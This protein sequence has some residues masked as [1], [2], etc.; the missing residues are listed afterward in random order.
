MWT[1]SVSPLV[2]TRTVFRPVF[3]SRLSPDPT[4]T[5]GLH[6]TI[7]VELLYPH[8]EVVDAWRGPPR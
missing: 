8:A 1:S 6:H 2:V 7:H 5:Q 3:E 4:V